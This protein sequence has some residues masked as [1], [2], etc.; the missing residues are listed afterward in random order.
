MQY[1]PH[2]FLIPLIAACC[3][4]NIDSQAEQETVISGT[5]SK[6][7][8]GDT[9]ELDQV[10]IRLHGISAPELSDPLGKEARLFITKLVF[11][12]SI[13]CR[14]TSKKSYDRFI[15]TC[16][17]GHQDIGVTIIEAGL[18][19]DCPRYSGSRYK[20]FETELARTQIR[21][22]VYCH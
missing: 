8:D 13:K 18:A 7:R 17:L 10:P 16:Y 19:L 21:L 1:I 4:P 22:P 3:L 2:N 11:G 15:G 6:V 14:L 5:V 9:I 20:K 12:K